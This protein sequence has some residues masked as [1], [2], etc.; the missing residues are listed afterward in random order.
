MDYTFSPY[1]EDHN[2]YYYYTATEE[3]NSFRENEYNPPFKYN[4]LLNLFSAPNMAA[5]LA[6]ATVTDDLYALPIHLQ[7]L[8]SEAKEEV[9]IERTR[10]NQEGEFSTTHPALQRLE[11]VRSYCWLRAGAD[12]ANS[13]LY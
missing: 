5:F 13:C 3:N 9:V 10:L 12:M 11:R 1:S 8:I 4:Y 6:E 2:D 7:R